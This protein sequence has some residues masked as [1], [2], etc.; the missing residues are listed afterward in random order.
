MA[1]SDLLGRVT[2]SVDRE[3]LDALCATVDRGLKHFA[4]AGDALIEIRDKQLYREDAGTFEAFCRDRWD[5]SG[6]YA[7][8]LMH[9]ASICRELSVTGSVPA[10]ERQARALGT[11]EP[12][13]RMAAWKEAQEETPADG[14][15]SGEAVRK[16]VRKR[17]N[18]TVSKSQ[19]K[20]RPVRLKV[21]GAVV[22]VE[23]NRRFPGLIEA[24]QFALAEA[25]KREAPIAKAA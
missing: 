15:V 18:T 20:L 14:V 1:L 17:S 12:A 23:P 22:V 8:K 3:R 9:A 6:D 25:E 5:M 2:P 13:E 24:L 4:D 11:L 10:T 7:R 21:P 16:A 19:G